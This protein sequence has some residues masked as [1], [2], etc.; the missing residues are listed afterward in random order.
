MERDFVLRDPLSWVY[1]G[2]FDR[3]AERCRILRWPLDRI[4]LIF[5]LYWFRLPDGPEQTNYFGAS[6]LAPNRPQKNNTF[7]RI[8]PQNE[9]LNLERL[10]FERLSFELLILNVSATRLSLNI[11]A[12]TPRR[13]SWSLSQLERFISNVSAGASR[14]KM[15]QDGARVCTAWYRLESTSCYI[16]DVRP[17][18]NGEHHRGRHNTGMRLIE[19]QQ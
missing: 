3:T 8:S 2:F 5:M 6:E 16:I 15:E 11:L 7:F 18:N 10:S 9:R 17:A 19:L 13:L 4:G 14:S 12:R 1:C